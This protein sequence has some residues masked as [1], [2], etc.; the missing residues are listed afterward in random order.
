[1]EGLPHDDEPVFADDLRSAASGYAGNADQILLWAE[2]SSRAGRDRFASG[3]RPYARSAGPTATRPGLHS[4]RGALR[5]TQDS[6]P[7]RDRAARPDPRC[8][9]SAPPSAADARSATAARGRASRPFA[10]TALG[11]SAAGACP[12][13]AGPRPRGVV[14]SRCDSAL[15]ARSR[16]IRLSSTS[17]TLAVASRIAAASGS[18]SRQRR[19]SR[20]THRRPATGLDERPF[21][22]FSS[23]DCSASANRVASRRCGVVRYL[24]RNCSSTAPCNSPRA[25]AS[26]RSCSTARIRSAHSSSVMLSSSSRSVSDSGSWPRR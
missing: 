2:D 3:R 6:P 22:E 18:S 5:R 14:R 13:P 25:N 15:V 8:R 19:V 10:A 12:P 26:T 16:S 21:S 23:R 7:A 1:M 17:H 9:R 11:R 20:T 24:E 4:R